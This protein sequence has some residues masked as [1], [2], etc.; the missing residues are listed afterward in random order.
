M[1]DFL[2]KSPVRELMDELG[3]LL[4]SGALSIVW[5][6][7][8]WG[9]TLPSLLSGAALWALVLLLRR[10]SRDG[11]LRRREAALRRAIGGELALEELLLLPPA[12][13]H[14][15]AAALLEKRCHLTILHPADGGVLCSLRGETVLLSFCQLPVSCAV[16]ARQVLVL[17]RAV[18]TAQARRG[19]LCAPCEITPAATAQAGGEIPVTFLGRDAL[20][21]LFG[22]ERPATDRQLVALGKRRKRHPSVWLPMI[23]NPRRALRYLGYGALLIAMHLLTG[24]AY[25]AVPGA[26]CLLLSAACRCLQPREEIL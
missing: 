15:K 4:L 10:K 7:F 25:Y 12:E 2:Q 23:L 11:R 18:R 20:I 1:Q 5:F 6:I 14:G 3:F 17:Q 8:L 13:A 22:S 19:I 24:L 16:D 26:I 9:V 21:S